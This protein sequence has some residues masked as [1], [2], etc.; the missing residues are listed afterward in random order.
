MIAS[1][2]YDG[3]TYGYPNQYGEIADKDLIDSTHAEVTSGGMR[4]YTEMEPPKVT[5]TGDD[6]IDG[7]NAVLT[8][9]KDVSATDVKTEGAI[10]NEPYRQMA[11]M[12]LTMDF[13]TGNSGNL[14]NGTNQTGETDLK[15]LQGFFLNRL[16]SE[17][18]L[19]YSPKS[20]QGTKD[21]MAVMYI[22]N[23]S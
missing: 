11:Y 21:R 16:P 23:R 19:K 13:L 17:A 10:R 8:I 4:L 12:D 1:G 2:Y 5:I 14:D 3:T 6:K 15:E 9:G 7:D 22:Q 20:I 18:E